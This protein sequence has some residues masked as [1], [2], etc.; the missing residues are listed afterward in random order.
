M[1]SMFWLCIFTGGLA[2]QYIKKTVGAKFLSAEDD[3]RGVCSL[4]CYIIYELQAVRN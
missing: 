3:H 4:H 2:P 1:N